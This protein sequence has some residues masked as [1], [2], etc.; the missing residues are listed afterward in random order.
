MLQTARVAVELAVT[1][2]ESGADAVATEESLERAE[3]L[4]ARA[5]APHLSARV[6][7]A[8]ARLWATRADGTSQE[9]A[10]RKA[11]LA[12]G[13]AGDAT[14]LTQVDRALRNLL[15]VSEHPTL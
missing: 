4:A 1:Q 5:E 12:A 8:M 10:L 2:L 15:Q 9:R 14:L 7:L 6:L 11:G 3:Q 13:R